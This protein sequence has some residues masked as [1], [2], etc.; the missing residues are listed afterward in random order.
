MCVNAQTDTLNLV[1]ASDRSDNIANQE[2][3][4]PSSTRRRV[5]CV[6]DDEDSRLM[7]IT[8]LRFSLIEA[9]EIATGSSRATTELVVGGQKGGRG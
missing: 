4:E 7:L 9:T 6:A 1:Q 5:L 8:L 2:A 3:T